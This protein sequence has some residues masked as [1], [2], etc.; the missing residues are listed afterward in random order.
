MQEALQR[1]A[2]NLDALQCLASLRSL[3]ERD[4]EAKEL[5]K[6]VVDRTLTLAD[7]HKKQTTVSELVKGNTS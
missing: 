6:R 7:E 1:D 4:S 3:R 5:L 2:T